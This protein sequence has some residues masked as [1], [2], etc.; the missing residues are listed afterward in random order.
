MQ[1]LILKILKKIILLSFFI[2]FFVSEI[3]FAQIFQFQEGDLIFI[4]SQ[5]AQA[6]A[7]QEATGSEWT[8]V[9]IIV[10]RDQNVMVAEA[11]QGVTVTP[12][13][14]FI[15]RSKNKLFK[16]ARVK[17]FN[18]LLHRE[19]L[20]QAIG[21]FYGKPYD[22]YFEFSDSKIYCSEFTYKVFKKILNIEI[23]Q[24]QKT[25]DLNLDGPYVQKLVQERLTPI[26]KQVNLN[27]LI[28]TPISQL[29]DSDVTL[30]N[31]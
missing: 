28:V 1:D 23:G 21:Q 25:G 7:V 29:I 4:Q 19:A 16:V 31:P 6:P 26:G 3:S 24:V 11:S 10:K 14:N 9:G 22:I 30:L 27:E 17:Q 12:I 8:H 5:T 18:L 13:L 2:S 20:Y 15:A